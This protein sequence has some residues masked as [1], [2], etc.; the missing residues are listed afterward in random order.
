MSVGPMVAVTGVVETL[1]CAQF[2]GFT[3]G[4]ECVGCMLIY[5]LFRDPAVGWSRLVFV[6]QLDLHILL[7]NIV[8][9]SGFR[10]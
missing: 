3:N 8:G 2:S 7:Y 6:P 9:P 5:N 4:A 1:V 10:W